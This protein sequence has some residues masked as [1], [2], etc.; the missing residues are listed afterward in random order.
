MGLN[1]ALEESISSDALIARLSVR[2]LSVE[3]E[4][5]SCTARR[6]PEERRPASGGEKARGVACCGGSGAICCG[7]GAG[8]ICS[9]AAIP[10]REDSYRGP[11]PP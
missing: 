1:Q 5:G 9:S 4:H 3:A 11:F 6:D 8:A 2:R 10:V 7:S